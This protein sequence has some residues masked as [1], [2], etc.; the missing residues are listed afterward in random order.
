MLELSQTRI[1]CANHVLVQIQSDDCRRYD[2][3]TSLTMRGM[4]YSYHP[5]TCGAVEETGRGR[6]AH[7][8]EVGG[9]GVPVERGRARVGAGA[10]AAAV[11][12]REPRGVAAGR[13]R[14]TGLHPRET[15]WNEKRYNGNWEIQGKR[16]KEHEWIMIVL[17]YAEMAQVLSQISWT[18]QLS[19]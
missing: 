12:R 7:V 11:R 8:G 14:A 3:I 5:L 2:W 10:P 1:C 16:R 6:D 4:K 19:H 15:W 17:L 13:E 9:G 18:L